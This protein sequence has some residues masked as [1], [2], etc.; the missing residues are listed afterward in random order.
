MAKTLALLGT[1]RSWVVHG[2]DGLDEITVGDRTFIAEAADGQVRTFEVGPEDFGL[3]RSALAELCCD[4]AETSAEIIKAVLSG[5]RSDAA[6]ALVLANAAALQVGGVVNDLRE[7]VR[8]AE[9]SI[10]GGKALEKLN[11][12]IERT[13]A[14][15]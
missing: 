14:G 3:A 4:D 12:L 9:E 6:R 15:N 7:G 8:L 11:Q 13:N 5:G 10:D 1:A 2:A